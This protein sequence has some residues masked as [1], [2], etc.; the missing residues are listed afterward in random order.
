[1]ATTWIKAIH[2][3]SGITTA[4][5][6]SIDYITDSKKTNSKSGELIDSF[7]CDHRTATSE[8]LL[9]KR[10]YAQRTGRNQG[11]KD[12]VAYHIRMSF[13]PGEVTA[14]Q[15]LELGRELANRWTKGKH[16]YIVV[17]HTNTNNPHVHIV[18][19]S[20]NIEA[21]GKF[22]DFKRS[23]I[24]L[25]RISDQICIE[26]GLSIIENPK[27][28]KGYNR[29][30]Y[31]GDSKS[32]SVRKQLQSI[33]DSIIPNCKDFE[34]FIIA[35]KQSGVEVKQGKQLSFKL[36]NGKRFTRQDTLGD[37][38]SYDAILERLSGKRVVIPKEKTSIPVISPTTP[39]LLID[40]EAK[41]QQGKGGGYEHW[42]KLFN[43]KAMSQTLIFI[44]ENGFASYEELETT[45]DSVCNE[46]NQRLEK[47]KAT[48]KRLAEIQELQKHIKVYSRTRETYIKYKRIGY[49]KNFYETNRTDITLHE[50]ARK[51]FDS[52]GY[53]KNNKLPPMQSL[54]QE[55]ATLLAEK[56]KL[57]VDYKELNER[58][59]ELLTVR[60]NADRILGIDKNTP[61]QS[62]SRSP[63]RND[64]RKR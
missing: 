7:M 47:I 36:P 31:L 49:N 63:Q 55:Y 29:A 62:Y 53:G 1:M 58:R 54:K 16:Q 33:M 45:T 52:L 8:F 38:Y 44:K 39:N 30:E 48:D 43:L 15:A 10:L 3:G 40:I 18:Y 2:K 20:V 50:A 26:Q 13:S 61:E 56:K 17:A 11:K 59:K 5:G 9:A 14:E 34:S 22:H 57:Y 41:I 21:T 12:V 46:Y 4:L 64:S 27:P 6:R 28:S 42:A 32:P 23:A 37:D 60:N 35:L 24:A 19:N 51:Y 25:R